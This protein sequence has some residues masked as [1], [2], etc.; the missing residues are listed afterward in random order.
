MNSANRSFQFDNADTLHPHLNRTLVLMEWISGLLAVVL[1]LLDQGFSGPSQ[2]IELRSLW[3]EVS[4][5]LFGAT[6]GCL[7]VPVL[8]LPL[9][10]WWSRA[11]GTFLKSQLL[12]VSLTASWLVGA[13]LLWLP[14]TGLGDVPRELDGVAGPGASL[15][16]WTE[17]F[18]V[19]RGASSL[20]RL[21]RW[22]TEAGLSPALVFV[23]SFLLLIFSGTAILMLPRCRPDGAPPATW[24]EALFTATSA[25]CVTGL[26]VV[27]PG[28][29]WSRTGQ[30]VILGLIQAGGLG[31]M[32]FGAFI[33]LV[34]TRNVAA[35]EAATFR[36][37]LESDRLG[38]IAGLIRDIVTLTLLIELAGAVAISG[39]WSHL[40][41]GE[42]IFYS[43]F[44]SVSAFC[45]AG[46]CL[47]AEGFIGRELRP[48]IWGG[49]TL[50]II[51]G[52]IGFGPLHN[53][54][55]MAGVHLKRLLGVAATSN[56]RTTTR[57]SLTTRIVFRVT[58]GLL[59]GGF[60]VLFLT[61]FG[62]PVAGST[63]ARQVANAWF[64]SVTLR[65]A[66]FNTMDH[67]QLSPAS[68]LVGIVWM[69]IGASP[70]S[71]GGGIKTTCF[72]MAILTLRSVLRQRNY[73]EAGGRTIPGELIL[74][75]LSIIALALMAIVSCTLAL[76]IIENHPT[77][78]LDHF[79]EATSAFAT[80]GV[81]TGIT[82]TLKPL[83]QL[84]LIVTMFVGRIG[85][86][87]LLVALAG[88]AS[89]A[90]YRYPDERVSLG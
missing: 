72:A 17:L 35:R 78:F 68:K 76:V 50:L 54:C 84:A 53:L 16:F 7:L 83:S 4:W 36:D 52:G 22:S 38:D 41:L 43:V 80:V 87:T 24:L 9:R 79:Y 37:L 48:E 89:Q 55:E 66:G 32:S 65:T 86:V 18:A 57:M 33:A 70:G 47:H 23:S 90:T 46:F 45:N 82:P 60:V 34:V 13:M 39:L 63:T 8:T 20:I 31:I 56:M 5:W 19:L 1:V 67:S 21:I 81:S 14:S 49:V 10:Y 73:V 75:G 27:D 25:S 12:L 71:T 15:L 85:A 3:P 26:N 11:R 29:Y 42:Q 2:A 58:L 61:E 74:R 88:S 69:F 28:T 51:L 59:V 64:H 44:H 6:V 77:Q 62:R 40:P 30:C